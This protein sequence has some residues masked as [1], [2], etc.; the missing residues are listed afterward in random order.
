MQLVPFAPF[1]ML[2]DLAQLGWTPLYLI[3]IA[4][5]FFFAGLGIALLLTRGGDAVN[6]FYAWDLACGR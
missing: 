1:S 4:T 5:P 2:S 3:L 6:R